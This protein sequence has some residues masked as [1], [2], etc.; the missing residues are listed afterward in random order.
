MAGSRRRLALVAAFAVS[1][2]TFAACGESEAEKA[3]AQV[4][5]SRSQIE[6]SVA[7]L[8]NLPPSTS[9]ISTAKNDFE[10]ILAELKKMSEA[11]PKLEPALRSKVETAQSDFKTS[12]LSIVG[13]LASG[14]LS[15][16]SVTS[17]LGD[18]VTQL[19]KSYKSTVASINCS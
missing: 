10:S 15:S 6:K 3:K 11:E 7:S 12:V 14:G 8:K 9:A 19:A 16:G 1:A 18:A 4:C 13:E 2:L 17:K 5:H